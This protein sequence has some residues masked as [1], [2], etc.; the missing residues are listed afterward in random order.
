M[1][2]AKSGQPIPAFKVIT[3]VR[4]HNGPIFE[5]GGKPAQNGR[6]EVAPFTYDW[7]GIAFFVQIT[8]DGYRPSVSR[9]I[10]PGEH[11]VVLDFKLEKGNGP[12][13]LVPEP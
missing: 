8:A 5:R 7:A 3:G 10:I 9:A 1:T 12:S 11:E 6:F 4:G 13:G 2:D